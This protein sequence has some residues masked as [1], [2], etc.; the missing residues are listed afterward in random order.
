MHDRSSANRPVGPAR[1][2]AMP[3]ESELS[4]TTLQPAMPQVGSRRS[5]GRSASARE[6]SSTGTEAQP[7][8]DFIF[9]GA[10]P[11]LHVAII[12]DGNARWAQAQNVSRAQG[13]ASGARRVAEIVAAAPSHGIEILTLFAFA[14]GNWNRPA[15]QVEHLMKLMAQS[16]RTE[17]GSAANSGARIRIIG[18]R[19]RVPPFLLSEITDAENSTRDGGG[20][21]LRI[22]IDYSS[23]ESLVKAADALVM[24]AVAD[25]SAPGTTHESFERA[26]NTASGS[27]APRDVDILIRT[28]GE[29]RLSDF[30]L[31]ECANAEIVFADCYW[32]D[33]TATHLGEIVASH[34]RRR[35]GS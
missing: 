35:P 30:M 1:F 22:A 9:P 15:A 18:R 13:H 2:R 7:S 34:K 21:E 10:I 29:H 26:A 19:D 4:A 31:W 6:M 11:A 20:M 5:Q 16:I 25:G 33:F 14:S 27:G 12:P 3:N 17:I 23:R 32:P 24:A 28:G 8:P